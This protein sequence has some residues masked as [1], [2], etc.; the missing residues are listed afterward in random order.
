M[1][2]RTPAFHTNLWWQWVIA[3]VAGFVVGGILGGGAGFIGLYWLGNVFIWIGLCPNNQGAIACFL[4][5][6]VL[7]AAITLGAV[8]GVAQ[9]WILRRLIRRSKWWILATALGWPSVAVSMAVLA[10]TNIPAPVANPDGTVSQRTIWD[11]AESI[12]LSVTGVLLAAAFLGF[13]Q[14]LVLRLSLRSAVWW[15]LMNILVWLIGSAIMVLVLRGGGGLV[16]VG[17]FFVGFSPVYAV[18]SGIVLGKLIRF[19]S[20]Q[21]A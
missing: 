10:Y 18:I 5:S 4:L 1:N 19:R 6:A 9:S 11:N 12:I 14:W 8:V 7:A 17:L 16:G 2:T 3:T 21:S 13:F 20:P 15:V